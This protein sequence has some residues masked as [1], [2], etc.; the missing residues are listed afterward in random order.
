MRSAWR[1]GLVEADPLGA[2][3]LL[4]ASMLQAIDND[5][6]LNK[7]PITK[8]TLSPEFKHQLGFSDASYEEMVGRSPL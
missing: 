6:T 2:N 5:E 1:K 4:E 8:L 3:E 7:F